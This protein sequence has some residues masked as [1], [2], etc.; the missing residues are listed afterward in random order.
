M[1][2]PEEAPHVGDDLD[3]DVGD[4]DIIPG[5][6]KELNRERKRLVKKQRCAPG[7]A[8]RMRVL[9]QRLCRETRQLCERAAE[10]E[11]QV[12]AF[13]FTEVA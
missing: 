7:F 4:I 8:E 5:S 3:E 12:S 11:R 9:G 6:I 1:S 13:K 2:E 10:E